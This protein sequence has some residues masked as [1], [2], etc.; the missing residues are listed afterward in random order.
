MNGSE[1]V[2][3]PSFLT[4]MSPVSIWDPVETVGFQARQEGNTTTHFVASPARRIPPSQ[5]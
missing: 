1:E 2:S 4:A 3:R 5:L